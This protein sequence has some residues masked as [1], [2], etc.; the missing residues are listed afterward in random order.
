MRF[1]VS[2]QIS[3]RIAE[4]PEG[5]L[6]CLD[7]PIARTGRMVYNK[8]TESD[9]MPWLKDV[10]AD[11]NGLVTVLREP[12]EVFRLDTMASFEGKPVTVDHPMDLVGP[13]NW[14]EFAKGNMQGVRRGYNDQADLL[15]SDF[16]IT[17]KTAIDVVRSREK[18]EVSCGYDAD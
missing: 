13:E 11:E 9:I 1:Y 18:R 5:F 8:K 16:L 6:V 14:A 4:T 2:E 3:P 7:V 17:D 15:L 10:E 12:D